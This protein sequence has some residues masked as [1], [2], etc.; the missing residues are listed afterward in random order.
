MVRG[1]QGLDKYNAVPPGR[2][3]KGACHDGCQHPEGQD[4]NLE[5]EI[6]FPT[7]VWMS[8]YLLHPTYQL[9]FYF[10]SPYI[11]SSPFQ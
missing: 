8:F 4:M 6:K 5:E 9:Q 1:Y 2:W 3:Q 7:N 10:M 11:S